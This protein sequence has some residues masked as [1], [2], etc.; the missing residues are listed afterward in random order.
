MVDINIDKIYCIAI[1]E[2]KKY[3]TNLLFNYFRFPESKIIFLDPF[4]KNKLNLDFLINNNILDPNHCLN[5]GEIACY[6][7]HYNVLNHF[8]NS[9]ST[10]ALILED[11][12]QK[13]DK[14]V[15]L[16]LNNILNLSLIHI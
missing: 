6:L 1:P 15:Y 2:R 9:N 5:K 14:N 11:D 12:L 8:Y 4:L 7:S 10:M 3:I 13:K 16:K